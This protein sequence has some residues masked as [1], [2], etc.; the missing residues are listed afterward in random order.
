M[1]QSKT[2]ALDVQGNIS[3]VHRQTLSNPKNK[4]N[5]NIFC[6]S[7]RQTSTSRTTKDFLRWWW[8]WCGRSS[9]KWART[10]RTGRLLK[11]PKNLFSVHCC[12]LRLLLI[13]FDR[14]VSK[15]QIFLNLTF[16]IFIS[17]KFPLFGWGQKDE[18]QIV[19]LSNKFRHP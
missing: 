14:F 17:L 19:F 15:T 13:W 10:G 2:K 5:N 7:L 8:R 1:L 9:S 6:W 11:L 16:E 3:L 18:M 12:L 4:T